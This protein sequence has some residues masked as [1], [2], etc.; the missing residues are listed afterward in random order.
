[1]N[2]SA[3][4]RR[5]DFDEEDRI[6]GLPDAILIH[7]LS[8]L[9]LT[10]ARNI[11]LIRIF[12]KLWPFIHTLT[13]DQCMFPWHNCHYYSRAGRIDYEERFLNFVRHVLLRNKSPTLDKFC[14]NFHFSLTHSIRKRVYNRTNG[15][16]CDFLRNEKRMA[17]E[18]GTWIQ[19]ALN[20]NLKVLELSFSAYG[21]FQPQT[22]YD[23]PNWVL[24]SPHLVELRLAFCKINTKKKSEL[25]SLTTFSLDNVMLM[26]QSMDY[27][28]SGCPMLEQLTLLFCYGH[29]R[30]VLLNSNLKRLVLGIRWF[31]TRIHVSCPTLLSLHMSGTVEVLDITNVASIV[32]ASV[33]RKEKFDFREY[34]DYQEMRI[35]FQTITGAK[36]L[37]LTSWFALV[38]SSWQLTNLPSPTFSC[39]S[40]HLQL[41]F[42]K[43]HLPG[44]LNLLKHCPCLENLIIKITSY[45]ESTSLDKLS[46]IHPYEFDADAYWS[47]VDIPVQCLTHH[48]KTVEVAGLVMEKQVIRFLEYLLGHSMML[49]QM[50][51]LAEKKIYGSIS[52]ISDKA[53]EYEERLMNAPKA[54]ASAVVFFY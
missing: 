1:M 52:L 7:I 19:F 5:C 34:K 40:L 41:D 53:H 27:I 10:D 30:V 36:S 13:F 21:T 35:F 6:S 38:F 24:S 28:L 17:N 46:W 26:E 50:K 32:E 16:L 51:I 29:R 12:Y 54:S 22:Y 49:K 9:P 15:W 3:R 2:M 18:I 8:L 31:G 48:L 44:I 4:Q 43:W 14:L 23:L 42:E 20:K 25:K 45:H 39:K 47:M 37:D 33:Y 11:I